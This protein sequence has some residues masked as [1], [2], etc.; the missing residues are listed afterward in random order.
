MHL[1]LSKCRG[2]A[3]LDV[4]CVSSPC[5]Y[6][7]GYKGFGAPRL[8][9]YPYFLVKKER[10]QIPLSFVMTMEFCIRLQIPFDLPE[11]G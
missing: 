8:F 3:A 9:I 11:I 5:A 4:V 10:M 7:H 1:G 2:Y 6:A